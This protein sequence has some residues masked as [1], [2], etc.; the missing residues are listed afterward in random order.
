MSQFELTETQRKIIELLAR[1]QKTLTEITNKLEISKS[2]ALKQLDK[3]VDSNLISKK[4]ETTEIGR[5]SIYSL[6]N[7]TYFFS[8]NPGSDS[9]IQVKTTSSFR[10]PFLLLEQV[11]QEKFKNE[12]KELFKR[13]EEPPFTI[14][15]GSV[16]K[17]EGTWKSDIDL[18]FLKESWSK[19]EKESINDI[20]SE[21]NM[22]IDHQITSKFRTF[23]RFKK[24]KSLVEEI[25]DSGIIIYDDLYER[26]KIWQ[27]MKRYKSITN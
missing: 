11:E 18:M 2:G 1:D 26:S 23:S 6:N 3:L 9:I 5:E 21:V 19:K 15:Y 27:R 8:L 22:E 24:G 14:L 20:I 17:G 7:F 4:I 12:I 13:L 10:L 16:A 25:K